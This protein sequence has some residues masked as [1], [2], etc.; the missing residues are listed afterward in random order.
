[1]EFTFIELSFIDD[2]VGE[3]EF[4]DSLRPVVFSRACEI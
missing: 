3:L 2:L 4:T 1:M